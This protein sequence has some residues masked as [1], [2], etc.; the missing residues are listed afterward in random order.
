MTIKVPPAIAS[1]QGLKRT[2]AAYRFPV[3]GF[4]GLEVYRLRVYGALGFTVVS[5]GGAAAQSSVGSEVARHLSF[6][7]TDLIGESEEP[8]RH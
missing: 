6:G 8:R 2:A 1:R 3:S 7:E 5:A 4:G